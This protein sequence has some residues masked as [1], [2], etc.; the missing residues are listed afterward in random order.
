MIWK[1]RK[2]RGCYVCLIWPINK[3]VIIW[4]AIIA[5]FYFNWRLITLQYCG[6]FCHT[7]T[8]KSHIIAFWCFNKWLQISPGS[9]FFGGVTFFVRHWQKDPCPVYELRIWMFTDSLFYSVTLIRL[10]DFYIYCFPKICTLSC[11]SD[12]TD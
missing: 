1:S 6:S 4:K 5:F 9:L 2:K 8:W 10:P 12:N 11:F 3:F 7:F